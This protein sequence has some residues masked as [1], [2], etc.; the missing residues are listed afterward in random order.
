MHTTRTS[1]GGLGTAN[2]WVLKPRE[3][4]STRKRSPP[5]TSSAR[6]PGP[7]LEPGLE[8]ER[9][10]RR[11]ERGRV[12][13]EDV[14]AAVARGGAQRAGPVDAQ[15]QL[16]GQA[17]HERGR[18]ARARERRARAREDVAGAGHRG[19]SYPVPAAPGSGR[20]DPGV[21]SLALDDPQHARV[22]DRDLRGDA[23]RDVEQSHCGGRLG[24]LDHDRPPE[25]APRAH[26]RVDRDLAQERNAQLL[27]QRA[28]ATAAEDIGPLLAV[29]ATK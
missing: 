19:A 22:L 26:A 20:Q 14:A 9:A 6:A 29:A 4:I 23:A 18:P 17:G 24:R 3:L 1:P 15:S 8:P 25:I 28:P 10:S 12:G 27:G 16:G 13:E 2:S 11:V 21:P 5:A 7:V